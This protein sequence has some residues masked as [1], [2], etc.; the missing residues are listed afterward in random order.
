MRWLPGLAQGG[1]EAQKGRVCSCL[2]PELFLS[3]TGTKQ[4]SCRQ[5][6]ASSLAPESRRGLSAEVGAVL[7]DGCCRNLLCFRRSLQA[8]PGAVTAR[9]R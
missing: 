2:L 4:L 1:E 3:P 5:G 9:T 8:R 7:V 6:S